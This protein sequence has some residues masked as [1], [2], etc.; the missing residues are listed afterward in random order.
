MDEALL[1]RLRGQIARGEIVLFVGA[2]F[3]TGARNVSGTSI[4][5]SG[6]LAQEL[7]AVAFPGKTFDPDTSLGDVY[8]AARLQRP[9]DLHAKLQALLTVD[10]ESIPDSY[11]T[12]FTM[13]WVRCYSLDLDDLE[14][15]VARKFSLGR[16]IRAISATSGQVDVVGGS[17]SLEVVHLNGLATDR[18]DDQVFSDQDYAR[19]N[20]VPNQW[21]AAWSTDVLARAVVFVG[22]RLNEST[23]WQYLEYRSRKGGRGVKEWRPGSYLVCPDLNAARQVV[24]AQLNIDWIPATAEEFAIS[25][26]AKLGPEVQEGHRSLRERLNDEEKRK[27]PRLVSELSAERE[28][29]ASPDYLVGKEP[30]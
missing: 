14:L 26:L 28:Y 29:V 6:Q 3:S 10:S 8:E 20:T 22:T 27:A 16:G 19:R 12:W 4:P 15:A 13:P 21:Y 24:L 5:D 30:T 1:A 23:L 7:W 11:R 17:D 18:V 9:K 2:G 25:V